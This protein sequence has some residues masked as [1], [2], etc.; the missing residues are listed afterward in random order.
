MKIV[1]FLLALQVFSKQLKLG[2]TSQMQIQLKKLT[3]SKAEKLSLISYIKQTRATGSSFLSLK[4]GLD[5]SVPIKNFANTQFVGTVGVGSPPQWI[6]V[7]FDTGS[8]NFWVNSKMCKESSCKSRPYYDHSESKDYKKDGHKISVQFGTGALEGKIS[9]DT[10]TIGGLEIPRQTFA[11]VTDEDGAVFTNARF[12]GLLGLSF[13][14]LGAPGTVPVFDHIMKSELLEQNIITFYYSLNPKEDSQL[15]F[16]YLDYSKFEGDVHWVPLVTD[17]LMYWLIEIED[18]R[19]GTMSLGVCNPKCHAAVDTGTSLLSAPSSHLDLIFSY[20]QDCSR[21]F[22]F[23]DIVLVI[24]GEEYSIPPKDYVIT[25]T[26]E[27][28][29]N[30]GL[31]S[32]GFEEC[33]LAFMSIDVPPPDGPLWILGDIFMASYY[34]IFDR[35]NLRVGFA[36]AFHKK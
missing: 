23:P 32:V 10:V 29:D 30:P 20:M 25:I 19:L 15:T 8:A 3:L 35:D 2:T 26:G 13:P 36:K 4:S 11:E 5:T 33:T 28:E 16:G 9:K 21:Y 14:S 22:E 27:G 24:N 1:I 18:V 6:D 7:I 17:L 31:H 12:S 34:T